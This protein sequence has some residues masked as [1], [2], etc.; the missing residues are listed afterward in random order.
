MVY[1]GQLSL[2]GSPKAR[3]ARPTTQPPAMVNAPSVMDFD[4]PSTSAPP[5]G[6]D[7]WFKP[8]STRRFALVDRQVNAA[9]MTT[10]V[11][12]VGVLASWLQGKLSW[13]HEPQVSQSFHPASFEVLT[14]RPQNAALEFHHALQTGNFGY[15]RKLLDVS[16]TELVDQA[17]K[18]C[19]PGCPT[20]KASAGK[21]FTR[22]TLLESTGRDSVVLAESFGIASAPLAAATYR[23]TRGEHGWRVMGRND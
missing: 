19:T 4:T 9:L 1:S 11:V 23:L 21:V 16:A 18:A 5:P 2:T 22:A 15:A 6:A 10:G 12:V 14:N 3:D 13:N 7:A 17:E 20:P 8:R